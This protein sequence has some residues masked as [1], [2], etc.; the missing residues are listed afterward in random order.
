MYLKIITHKLVCDVRP[1]ISHSSKPGILILGP[2][3]A[4]RDTCCAADS[5]ARNSLQCPT[6]GCC[7]VTVRSFPCDYEKTVRCHR[8]EPTET[9]SAYTIDAAA[10]PGAGVWRRLQSLDDVSEPETQDQTTPSEELRIARLRFKY[11]AAQLG[12]M[13]KGLMA[14]DMKKELKEQSLKNGA[15]FGKQVH[16]ARAKLESMEFIARDVQASYYAW[17]HMKGE[18]E[19]LICGKT[20]VLEISA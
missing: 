2:F 17:K 12:P 8:Y 13:A 5:T 14:A 19:K 18:F 4:P 9:P 7:Q 20:F 10:I 3:A 11:A 6:R 16:V 15:P 1:I